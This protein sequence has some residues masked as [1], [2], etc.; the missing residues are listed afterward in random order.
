MGQLPVEVAVAVQGVVDT[1]IK[2]QPVGVD[3]EVAA[4]EI[5][6]VK[7]VLEIKAMA[8]EVILSAEDL[9]PT[10]MQHPGVLVGASGPAVAQ[11]LTAVGQTQGLLDMVVAQAIT[12]W[13]THMLVG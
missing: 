9:E 8:A 5:H 10:E 13:A 2:D 1:M 12:L 3:L 7:V 11:E 6:L 4:L